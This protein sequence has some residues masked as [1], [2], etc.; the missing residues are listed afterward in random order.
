LQVQLRSTTGSNQFQIGEQIPLEAVLSSSIP[1][2]YLEPCALFRESSFG[3]ECRFFSSWS[4]SITPDSGW[5]DLAK[6][7][8]GGPQTFGGPTFEVQSNDL[9]S[10]PQSYPYLLTHKFRFDKPGTY[11]V[12]LSLEVGLDD[13]STQRRTVPDPAR[14]PHSVGVTGTFELQI[15]SSSKEWQAKIVR[16]GN[17]AY[18]EPAPRYTDPPSPEYLRHMQAEQA[19]CNLGTPE[20]ARTLV[21]LLSPEHSEV[22][23]CLDH[24]PS[25]QA[26][27]EEMQRLLVDPEVGVNPQLFSEL[28]RLVGREEFKTLGTYDISQSAADRERDVL[29]SVLPKK[30]G[31]GQVTSL[32]TVL[33]WPP[34]AKGTAL[35]FGY[36]LP[37]PASV[38]AA[39]VANFDDFPKDR[40]EWLL[41]E[42]WGRVRSPLMLPLVRRLAEGGNGQAVLRWTE[43]DSASATEFVRKEVVRPVPRFSSFYLRLPESSLPEQEEQ[44]AENVVA[45]TR[46]EDLFKGATLLHRYATVSVLP[47]VLPFID[48]KRAAWPASVQYPMFAYLLKVSPADAAPR[49]EQALKEIN[50]QPWQSTFFSDI[51]SLEPSPVLDRLAIAQIEDGTQPLARDAVEY[52]RLHGS[53]A[54]KPLLWKQLVRW[55]Q[56]M[57]ADRA[58]QIAKAKDSVPSSEDFLQS[59]QVT[60]LTQAFISAQ[61]WVLSPEDAG[62]IRA[63]FGEQAAAQMS[64]QFQCGASLGNGPNP[65]SYA[66]YGKTNRPRPDPHPEYMNP[67]ERLRYYI[68]Q[69]SCPD[70]RALKE[71]LLQLPAGSSFDF[72]WDFSAADRAEL[73]EISDFLWS[74][75]YKVR[76]P[77]HWNFLRTDSPN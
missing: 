65:G 37:F 44:I 70:M 18:N 15:V 41:G 60:A 11:R 38:I 57:A 58:A 46:N 13:E 62:N 17:E 77:Q 24:T 20:A 14:K 69:Y 47:K 53:P 40:K 3:L 21:G 28:V 67:T 35:D 16:E 26:A 34:R 72:V 1:N 8:P 54:A 71:K 68:N 19:L 9:T 22:Q 48:E 51:G 39:V 4:F 2:R 55:H 49:V 61:G 59:A 25:P 64:C 7:F 66:I 56:H 45:L 12:Q 74:H 5:V 6:E 10:M 32:L 76:N 31:A 75:G 30:R 52:L 23:Q 29:V 27:I 50:H 42:A 36:D 33:Q 63:L 43:L 73:V